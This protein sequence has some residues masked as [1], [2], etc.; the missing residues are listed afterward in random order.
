[1]GGFVFVTGVG[2]GAALEGEEIAEELNGHDMDE[3]RKPF[4]DGG[5]FEAMSA[6][7]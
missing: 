2:I 1:V 7:D 5:D 4:G 6:G 3:R